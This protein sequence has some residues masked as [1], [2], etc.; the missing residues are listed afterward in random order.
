MYEITIQ[1]IFFI[2]KTF[3]KAHATGV[4]D[5]TDPSLGSVQGMSEDG[6][7][8]TKLKCVFFLSSFKYEK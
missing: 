4:E 1:N 7:G 5:T 8:A 2:K 6:S 3:F